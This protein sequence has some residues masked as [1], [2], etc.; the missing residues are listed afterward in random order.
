MKK[1][2]KPSITVFFAKCPSCGAEFTYEK[3]DMLENCFLDQYIICPC[4]NK[5]IAH[6]N[7][8]YEPKEDKPEERHYVDYD[9]P[10]VNWQLW[11]HYYDPYLGRI[12]TDPCANCPNKSRALEI[13]DSPCQWCMYGYRVTCNT[14]GGNTGGTEQSQQ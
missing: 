4:C 9:Y 7:I 1:I 6:T 14:S 12:F 11:N 8:E 10:K 3:D 5:A 13:G 2:L